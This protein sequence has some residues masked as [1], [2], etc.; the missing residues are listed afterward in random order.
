[1]DV[2][3]RKFK[4]VDLKEGS[5]MNQLPRDI[6]DD[7]DLSDGDILLLRA[8]PRGSNSYIRWW[9]HLRGG[10]EIQITKLFKDIVDKYDSSEIEFKIEGLV[11]N[12]WRRE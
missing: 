8:T 2:R 11:P 5:D 6:I 12:F 3:N 9:T 7:L 10:K 1:M 4:A